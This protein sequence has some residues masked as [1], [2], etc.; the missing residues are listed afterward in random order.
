MEPLEYIALRAGLIEQG[1]SDF[2]RAR[3]MDE[4]SE[5]A[6]YVAVGGKKLRGTMT[7]LACEGMGGKPEDAVIAACAVELAHASSLVKDDVMDNDSTRRGK[8]AFWKRFGLEMAILLPDV[9][10]PHAALFTHTYGPRAFL[11]IITA[12]SKIAQGQLLDYPRSPQ[13]SAEPETQYE[14]IIAL[15]TASLFE[16]ACDLGVR[17]AH[18]EWLVGTGT[19]YGFNCGM[20][21]QIVDDACD[22]QRAIGKPWSE[23]AR[24]PLPVSIRALKARVSGVDLVRE[25]DFQTAMGLSQMY[26]DRAALAAEAFINEDMKDTLRK[27]PSFCCQA[28]LA[29]LG[30][31]ENS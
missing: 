28:L 9:I 1:L 5:M 20:A 25:E 29:E 12:W 19:A 2:I 6:T 13:K 23:T 14:R 31:P 4:F 21:F 26:L 17:A 3:Y 22:L 10:I 16:A 11:S 7:L 15:K 8:P 30:V 24:G 27:L 18:K